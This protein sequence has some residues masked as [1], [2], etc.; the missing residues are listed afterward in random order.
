[1]FVCIILVGCALYNGIMYMCI[2]QAD[3]TT[4]HVVI[5]FP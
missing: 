3:Y 5:V 4:Y 2:C 1:M